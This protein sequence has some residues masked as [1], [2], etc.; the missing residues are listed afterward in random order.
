MKLRTISSISAGL[1]IALLAGWWFEF[2]RRHP[3]RRR[4]VAILIVIDLLVARAEHRVLWKFGLE[5]FRQLGHLGPVPIHGRRDLCG[6]RVARP[7]H[8]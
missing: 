7:D 6:L 4:P 3:C 1:L 8:T 2:E 5:R